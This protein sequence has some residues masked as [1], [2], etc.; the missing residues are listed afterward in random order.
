LKTRQKGKEV[1]NM[2]LYP[3]QSMGIKAW[4]SDL[5]IEP[6]DSETIYFMSICGYQATVK[7]IVAN[8]LENCG[9]S[10]EVDGIEHDLIRSDTGYKVLMKKLP[11]GL[12]HAVVLPK[13]AIPNNDEDSRNLFFVFA[14]R[15]QDILTLFFRHLDDKT[16]IPLHPS[17]ASWL[18]EAFA[19]KGDWLTE[20]QTLAG[21]FKGYRFDYQP[22]HL[23]DLIANAIRGKVPEV[24]KCMAW[25]GENIDGTNDLA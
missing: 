24:V 22:S 25:K 23:H 12:I 5:I 20:L 21:N 9:I 19:K 8:L 13:Q 7:G 6:E 17:W 11:S 3:I 18:W 4:C 10:I 16:E 15:D 2:A 1:L 14:K